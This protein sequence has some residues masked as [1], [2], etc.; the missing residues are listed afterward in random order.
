MKNSMDSCEFNNRTSVSTETPNSYFE[1]DFIGES[2][3][4]AGKAENLRLKIEID[5]KIMAAGIFIG[6]CGEKEIF[7]SRSNM[8]NTSHKLKLIVLSGRLEFNNAQTFISG[9][10]ILPKTLINGSSI[11]K[12]ENGKTLKKSTLLMGA[13]LAAAGTG[14]ILLRKALKKGKNK[15]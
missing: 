15:K 14:L 3:A 2:V 4:F 5:D 9:H 13:G 1:F 8:E 12:A 11:K 10:H 7:Y 6:N